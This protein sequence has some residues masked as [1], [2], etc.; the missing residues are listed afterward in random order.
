[1]VLE[2][3]LTQI[4]DASGGDED[5]YNSEDDDNHSGTTHLCSSSAGIRPSPASCV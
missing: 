4:N 1:V 5:Y 2:T 3:V